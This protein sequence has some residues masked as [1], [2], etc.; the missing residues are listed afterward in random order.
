MFKELINVINREPFEHDMHHKSDRSLNFSSLYL[1]LG[2]LQLVV[3]LFTW[4]SFES[5]HSESKSAPVNS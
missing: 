5:E 2:M 1:I 4:T 3:S